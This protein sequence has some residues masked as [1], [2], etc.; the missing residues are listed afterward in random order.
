M[1]YQSPWVDC[2]APK[3]LN[4]LVGHPSHVRCLEES[5]KQRQYPHFM[6]SGAPGTS[7]SSCARCYVNDVIKSVAMCI[8]NSNP[9][10]KT[11]S[12]ETLEQDIRRLCVKEINASVVLSANDLID[13][14]LVPFARSE[15]PETWRPLIPHI[16]I[17]EES[18]NMKEGTQQKLSTLM[19]IYSSSIQIIL[20]LNDISQMSQELVDKCIPMPFTPLSSS[21]MLPLL[22]SIW[23][24]TN[25]KQNPLKSW[26]DEVLTAL[27]LLTEGDMRRILN[28]MHSLSFVN[29]EKIKSLEKMYD[30]DREFQKQE[31]KSLNPGVVLMSDVHAWHDQSPQ[32]IIWT[33]LNSLEQLWTTWSITQ[34]TV[35][36]ED[37]DAISLSV[38]K[39]FKTL[40]ESL[41]S[42]S[43]FYKWIS[44]WF[45]D[46][47]YLHNQ[48]N[49]APTNRQMFRKAFLCC[50]SDSLIQ[51]PHINLT[52]YCASANHHWSSVACAF[53]NLFPVNISMSNS[54]IR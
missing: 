32:M 29:I 22:K 11:I 24:Q 45:F 30:I 27:I 23:L 8:I 34:E 18:D 9:N 43:E 35:Q 37:P 41:S 10:T 16:V 1:D 54:I 4:Q 13:G 28:S 49:Q 3:A 6:L 40:K 38:L 33:C 46:A 31:E 39:L 21:D 12:Q 53:L 42:A 25:T 51:D 50:F 5:I 2:F 36:P 15:L 52:D 48:S 19:K 44:Y 14:C 20:V 26:S 47:W 7:K 17:L